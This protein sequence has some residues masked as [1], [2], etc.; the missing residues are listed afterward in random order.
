MLIW[1]LLGGLVAGSAASAIGDRLVD[2]RNC[3]TGRSACDHCQ[4][5]LSWLELI[6]LLS[7]LWQRGRC[8]WCQ[9]CIAWRYPLLELSGAVAWG[10]L[11]WWWPLTTSGF[12]LIWLIGWLVA[13]SCFLILMVA[14]Y[15]WLVL[16]T[17]VIMVLFKLGV[18]LQL[19]EA[20]WVDQSPTG[21]M[22][23]ALGML[24]GGGLFY[25]LYTI[26][27]KL[28]GFGDVRLGAALGVWLGS[29]QLMG[30][31]IAVGSWIGL[32]LGIVW[33]LAKKRQDS[34]ADPRIPFGPALMLGTL[35]VWLS[36]NWLLG[37]GLA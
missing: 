12:D 21:L 34:P 1:V 27:P 19:A 11:Y 31:T 14:D 2:G 7:W 3:L 6:P 22:N 28:I 8:R 24:I 32:I 18:L 16:P 26:S 5:S 20:I 29:A 17:P 35:V 13:A 30:W 15:R 4:H 23:A 25:L 36:S 9:Q 37:Q 10:A 33:L